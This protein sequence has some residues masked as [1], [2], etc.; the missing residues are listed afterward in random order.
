M[1]ETKTALLIR[2]TRQEAEAI[3]AAAARERRTISG[4]ILNA[5]RHRLETHNR[6]VEQYGPGIGERRKIAEGAEKPGP[7]RPG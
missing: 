2:C 1:P 6:L 3:R 5:I 4:F 7:R